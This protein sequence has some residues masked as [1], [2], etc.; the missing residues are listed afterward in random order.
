MRV[1]LTAGAVFL[2][3]AA[4]ILAS[5]YFASQR[6]PEFYRRAIAQKPELQQK[7]SE[8]L[9]Q[10][11]T[12]LASDVQSSRHWQ[13]LFTE[14]QIN[15][16]LAVDRPR[17]FPDLLPPE[18]R[19]PRV[20]I[21]EEEATIAFRYKSG[22]ISTVF[23]IK[24]DIYLESSS[25]VALHVRSAHA[26]SVPVPLSDVL[27]T[28][29]QA[30]DSLEV[31]LVWRQIDGEPVAL[32]TIPAARDEDNRTLK[33]E[34]IELHDGK[35]Y[36]AGTSAREGELAEKP[37]PASDGKSAKKASAGSKRDQAEIIGSALKKN[38]QR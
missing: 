17:H 21:E 27:A 35:I 20:S 36:L 31:P 34:T 26:G 33:L 13:A 29:G 1:L 19:D 2:L 4:A 22:K 24:F 18:V 16:W 15:G 8:E 3:T 6:V 7:D 9:L 11:A 14:K 23:S 38:R 25:I 37:D 10:Q 32:I 12:A 5:V 30:A 28:I